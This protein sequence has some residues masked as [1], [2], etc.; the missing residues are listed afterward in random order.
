MI[1]FVFECIIAKKKKQ[2]KNEK[3]SRHYKQAT[4]VLARLSYLKRTRQ[5]KRHLCKGWM[6]LMKQ[7]VFCFIY[8][9][10]LGKS[11]P[12]GESIFI[13]SCLLFS[14]VFH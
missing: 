12:Y 8:S 11:F 1:D 3:S 13:H 10:M 9:S 5:T 6:D 4:Y 7:M 2:P 14:V